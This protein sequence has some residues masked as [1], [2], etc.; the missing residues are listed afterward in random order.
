MENLKICSKCIQSN[1]RPGVFFNE[2]SIC[3]A[4]LWEDEKKRLIGPKEKKN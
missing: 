4:C 3:G 2:E 1:T